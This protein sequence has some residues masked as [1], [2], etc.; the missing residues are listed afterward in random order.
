MRRALVKTLQSMEQKTLRKTSRNQVL[1]GLKD[2]QKF[3][4]ILGREALPATELSAAN[5]LV[6]SVTCRQPDTLDS[7]SVINY[8]AGQSL[9]HSMVREQTGLP[10]VNPYRTKRVRRL[11]KHLAENY[12]KPSKAKR[13]WSIAQ[14]R[15][16]YRRGF[17]DTRSGRHQKLC[18]MF[19]NLGMLR[20]NAARFLRVKYTIREGRVHY[21][22]S[23]Q[24]R[25]IARGKD[26]RCIHAT[27]GAD[28]NVNALKR[29]D[30][31]IPDVV[32]RLD[33][34]PADMLDEYILR[35][36]P[37]S[38]GLLLAAPLGKTAQ[39][40]S[41]M[42]QK[43]TCRLWRYSEAGALVFSG[44]AAN[45]GC[46]GRGVSQCERVPQSTP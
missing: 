44:G 31:Y 14:A 43:G 23:S 42:P 11:I 24:V 13:P 39:S 45:L 17:K 16:I 5:Y 19:S 34:R 12:K 40:L 33:V 26:R 1:R 37:P 35:E 10:L 3:G 29:R 20:K 46:T 32:H 30:L 21:A 18:F 15:R 7:S 4:D 22:P 9:W 6:Y 2:F 41:R 27:V 28:K 36:R 8:A 38:G 25:V